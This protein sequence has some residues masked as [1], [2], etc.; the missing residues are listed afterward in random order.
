[1]K[2]T[3]VISYRTDRIDDLKKLAKEKD[4]SLS[5]LTSEIIHDYLDHQIITKNF[6][7]F[8]SGEKALS[9]AFEN[10]DKKTLEKVIK[11]ATK[12]AANSIKIMT[13]EFSFENISSIIRKW[14]K[15]NK[16]DLKEFHEKDTIKLVCKTNLSK[17]FNEYISK[18]TVNIINQ[19]G[20]DGI[21]RNEDDIIQIKISKQKRP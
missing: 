6:K 5:N 1:M 19:F 10:L 12:E 14:F 13:D 21:S 15:Y 17:N 18:V 7:M 20:Y 3:Q 11:I 9:A 4:V 8:C 2:M 16:F